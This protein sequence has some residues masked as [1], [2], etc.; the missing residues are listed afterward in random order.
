VAEPCRKRKKEA[1]SCKKDADAAVCSLAT[2]SNM[3]A[4]TSGDQDAANASMD[5]GAGKLDMELTV[6]GESNKDKK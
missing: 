5:G 2:T 1:L 6:E 3:N 4:V